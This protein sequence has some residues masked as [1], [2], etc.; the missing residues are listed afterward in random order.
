MG[1]QRVFVSGSKSLS[2][3]SNTCLVATLTVTVT[4]W[5]LLRS[6]GPFMNG[7]S[8]THGFATTFYGSRPRMSRGRD[9]FPLPSPRDEG[10]SAR[11]LGL[12]CPRTEATS[13]SS[14][15]SRCSGLL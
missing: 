1:R 8:G 3:A 10:I 14:L 12:V 4:T 11:L 13:A 5:N 2:A 15:I 7:V 6:T 9:P